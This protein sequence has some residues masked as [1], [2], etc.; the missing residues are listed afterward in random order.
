MKDYLL[1]FKIH[2]LRTI[3]SPYSVVDK[4][5][6]YE[7]IHIML[8]NIKDLPK[9]IPLDVNPREQKMTTAV[10]NKL[11]NAVKE[12]S[13]DFYLNNRGIVLSAKSLSFNTQ[14]SEI[15]IDIGD[16]NNEDDRY[17][18]GILDGGH[19][20]KAIISQRDNLIDNIDRYVKLEVI[21]N[22]QNI[23]RLSDARNTSIQV[24]DVAL[25]NL[26]DK[27]NRIKR[28]IDKEPYSLEIAYK[29]N[30]NKRL[31]VYELLKLLYAMDV[32]KFPNDINA[33]IQAYSG[34]AQVFKR[35]KDAY[36]SDFYK[37]LEKLLPKFVE[38]YDIIE[39]ELPNKY[40]EY[41]KANGLSR[42]NFGNVR[43]IDGLKETKTLFLKNKCNYSISSGYIFPIFG[44]FRYL[45]KYDKDKG[46]VNWLFD[47]IKIWDSIGTTLVQNTFETTT[48][49]NLA[50]KDKQL[51][52]TNYRIVETQ[53][54]R[55]LL[56]RENSKQ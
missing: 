9:N 16:Q 32:E 13:T 21:T 17:L 31:H 35:Y 40:E 26:D 10:A 51:W 12:N 23:A 20:Y 24:S 53:C 3:P 19:T 22:V 54:L 39:I 15:S 42:A 45:V 6:Q 44:A 56:L 46:K 5:M 37:S 49:P 41:K 7:T 43:G 30:E 52:L 34:K 36:D 25:F 28:I 14:N 1:K 38:L 27:F 48:N 8:V 50:G 11:I 55:E 18:Y 33:P 29:D 4:N 47:P 2:T